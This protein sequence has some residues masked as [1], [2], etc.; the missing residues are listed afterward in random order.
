MKKLIVLLNTIFILFA[1]FDSDP[2]MIGL[3]GAYTSVAS[4]YH[5]IGINPANLGSNNALSMNLFSANIFLVNDF[6]SVELYNDINGANL[7]DPTSASYYPKEDILDQVNENK[8]IMEG[9]WVAPIPALNFA[10]KRFGIS[11]VNRSYIRFDLPKDVLTMMFYGNTTERLMF[12]F[13]GEG[14]SVNE[15]GLTY[16]H[17]FL[18]DNQPIQFGATFKYLQGL[19]YLKAEDVEDEGSYFE[20]DDDSFSGSGR[21][22][23]RQAFGGGGTAI[24]VG[25]LL[26]NFIEGWNVGV[27]LINLGGSI[28][29]GAD[30]PTRNIISKYEDSLPL[31]QNE[32][33]YFNYEIEPINAMDIIDLDGGDLPFS[34][35]A[36]TVGLLT[37]TPLCSET[38]SQNLICLNENG[39]VESNSSLFTTDQIIEIDDNSYLVPS[40][41]LQSSQLQSQTSEDINLDYPSFLRI[42]IS[43][44]I[45]NYGIIS[46]DAITGFDE[47]F[48]NSNKF[49]LSIGTEIVAI[50]KKFP[51][52]F[53]LS[54]GG[55]QLSSYSL[56]F[57]YRIGP[58]SLDFG[59]KYYA[60]L[61]M[62]KAK[63]VEYAFNIS[64]DF[65]K[66][67]FKDIFRLNLP[68]I[69]L[70]ELPKLPD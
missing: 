38:S 68:K 2:R 66:F 37:D 35:D 41:L 18:L 34:S 54:L 45:Q 50:S 51:V 1:Q 4:G 46:L 25:L 30:N 36:Y 39:E 15:L 33:Y 63:G 70:P 64:L 10:Y 42:G 56:G 16:A 5:S 6:M 60:G 43:K 26:P 3:S 29:W 23:V 19:L 9:G 21:Y 28:S 14:I 69:K 22:L 20:T 48:G 52:R 53:G 7:E 58:L 31:R 13:G 62:N 61:I 59:R 47:S 55:R 49:K 24:D 57:G 44:D 12:E 17:R 67:S 65:N 40:E 32:Y 11:M 27:S 8:I